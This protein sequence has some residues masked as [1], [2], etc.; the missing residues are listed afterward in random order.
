VGSVV[1][2]WNQK[3]RNQIN[4]QEYSGDSEQKDDLFSS[5]LM[6]RNQD[7]SS[8]ILFLL[9]PGRIMMM[10]SLSFFLIEEDD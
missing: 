7:P 1:L 4:E 9:H 6:Y 10:L 2:V 3:N 8:M 5:S